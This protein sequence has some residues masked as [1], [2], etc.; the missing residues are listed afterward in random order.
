MISQKAFQTRARTV[1]H[2]GREQIADCPTAISELWKNSFD[3]YARH[4]ELNIYDGKEPVAAIIDDG[5]GMSLEEFTSRW[6]VVG[7]EPKTG[8][9]GVP[10]GDREG[11]RLRPRQGQKGIGRLSCANLGPV[12]LLVSKRVNNLFVAAL[13]NWNLFE[14]PF[15]SLSDIFIPIIEFDKIEKLLKQLP[16]LKASLS[17]NVT[18]GSDKFRKK[19]ILD[20]WQ[21]FD[22]FSNGKQDRKSSGNTQQVFS[23]D[24][25]SNISDVPFRPRHLEQW[26]TLLESSCHGTAL[27]VSSIN[28]DLRVQLD[29]KTQDVSAPC[30]EGP[31]F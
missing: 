3:A 8:D 14:N 1:D 17:E 11:L 29:E 9:K 30:S 23:Q 16:D 22:E 15:L 19:R 5:H 25:L 10:H 2:L 31:V 7:T 28:Y 18:G 27:L 21:K 12:L 24:V 4:V 20:A 6:L 13:I 26:I